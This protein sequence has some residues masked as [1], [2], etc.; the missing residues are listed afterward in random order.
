MKEEARKFWDRIMSY[1][2]KGRMTKFVEEEIWEA[3]DEQ[4]KSS[5]FVTEE[6]W[7]N[8]EEYSPCL[9]YKEMK[10]SEVWDTPEE[11]DLFAAIKDGYLKNVKF[12]DIKDWALWVHI[13]K[14]WPTKVGII[15]KK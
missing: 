10:R 15:K 9:V 7:E 3:Y 12:E 1:I 13:H 8:M 5:V 4:I 14:G 11:Y 2:E 6:E